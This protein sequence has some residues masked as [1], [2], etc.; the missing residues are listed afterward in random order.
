MTAVVQQFS[1]CFSSCYYKCQGIAII[2]L[3]NEYISSIPHHFRVRL[4]IVLSC[5][6]TSVSRLEC[7]YR[8][9]SSMGSDTIV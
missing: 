4:L 2:E 9:I 6:A 3:K 1:M 7:R 5:N 8:T